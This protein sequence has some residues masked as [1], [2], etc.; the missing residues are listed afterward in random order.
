[1][2]CRRSLPEGHLLCA[3]CDAAMPRLN[4]PYCLRCSQPFD[5][6]I[7]Q[8]F[9]CATCEGRNFRFLHA[10]STRRNAGKARHLI[11]R[12]KYQRQFHLRHV[13]GQW[14]CEC[15]D[16]QR[17]KPFDL[18]MPV[19]LHPTRLREREF[20]QAEAI[21]EIL[22]NRA[23]KPLCTALRRIRR[24]E[25][26]THFQRAQRMKNLHNAF[27]I[28]KPGQIRDRH[29]LL[30]DDVFTTGSTVNECA[31]TLLRHGAAS[32]QVATAARS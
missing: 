28:K 21:A 13:L 10:I 20:N 3:E 15:L 24:T 1:M 32:V 16:D 14:L 11:H 2:A 19:P 8:D 22:A 31:K 12:F 29:I 26:Q 25:T 7:T 5:G 4:P 23:G 18:V 27:D 30:V 9:V 17:L 6:E